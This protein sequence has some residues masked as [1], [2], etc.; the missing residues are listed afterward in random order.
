MKKR[1]LDKACLTLEK[2]LGKQGTVLIKK[3]KSELNEILILKEQLKQERKDLCEQLEVLDELK[4]EY[5]N[6]IDAHNR[7]SPSGLYQ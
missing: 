2:A 3:F 5:N 7:K 1:D 4:L 6:M